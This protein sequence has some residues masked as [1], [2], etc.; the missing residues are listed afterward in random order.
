VRFYRESETSSRVFGYLDDGTPACLLDTATGEQQWGE[1][2]WLREGYDELKRAGADLSVIPVLP[3]NAQSGQPEHRA[4]NDLDAVAARPSTDMPATAPLPTEAPD[5]DLAQN[6][7][8]DSL[9]RVIADLYES[10]GDSRTLTKEQQARAIPYAVGFVGEE[11]VGAELARLP[12]GAWRVLHSI[13]IGTGGRDVD[14]LVIGAGGVFSINT[15][16]HRGQNVDVKDPT[17]YV[18]RYGTG[19]LPEARSEAG[20]ILRRLDVCGVVPGLSVTPV[21]AVVGARLRLKQASADVLV[22][23][24]G[25]LVDRLLG[26][27]ARLTGDQVEQ[28]FAAARQPRTWK[29]TQPG[30][31]PAALAELARRMGE[32]MKPAYRPSPRGPSPVVRR[33]PVHQRSLPRRILRRMIGVVL[34]GALCL[35]AIGLIHFGL[36]AGVRQLTQVTTSRTTPGTPA[37]TGASLV[38]GVTTNPTARSSSRSPSPKAPA[39][40]RYLAPSGMAMAI[41][42]QACPKQNG[43][44]ASSGH[45]LQCAKGADGR[46]LW[47]YADP[48]LRL[49]QAT[50][51]TACPSPGAHARNI[52][53]TGFLVCTRKGSTASWSPD[54]TYSPS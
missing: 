26:E 46:R 18:G 54:P 17:V 34:A 42:G 28:L 51:N 40:T 1:R 3:P 41:P 20:D 50:A 38:A 7:P 23:D 52:V 45:L 47:R 37:T 6:R 25:N 12:A 15:K 22:L 16:H 5:R 9:L 44:A 19:Y 53:G 13:T 31:P 43:Q 48:A 24:A 39:G 11:Q 8:G 27:P 4:L 14:H 35:V 32:P 30:C 21:V 29:V 36:Q 10:S 49:P 33:T 2:D